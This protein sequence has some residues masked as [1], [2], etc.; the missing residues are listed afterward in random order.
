MSEEIKNTTAEEPVVEVVATDPATPDAP[1]VDA[2]PAPAIPAPAP[3]AASP[4]EQKL[5]EYGAD[6]VTIQKILDL[7]V[8][9]V[10]DLKQLTDSD[11]VGAGMKLV[12]ARKLISDFQ[13]EAKAAAATPTAASGFVFPSAINS[14][15][16]SVPTDEVWMNSLKTGGVLRID[17]STYIA[18]IKT[19]LAAKVGLYNAPQLLIDEMERYAKDIGEPVDADVFYK[20][21]KM[22]T[23][24]D[25]SDI[26][27][28][29]DGCSGAFINDKRRKEFLQEI[30]NHFLPAIAASY[31]AL[32]SWYEGYKDSFSDQMMLMAFIAG[33]AN[34]GI[35]SMIQT[36]D[37]SVVR[38]AR[39]TF[40][41]EINKTF[42]GCGVQSASAL[43]LIARDILGQLNDNRLP[44]LVGAE[45][46]ELMLKKL[47]LDVSSSYARL[48]QI[49]SQYVLAFVKLDEATPDTEARYLAALWQL[50]SQIDWE[51]LNIRRS[52]GSKSITGRDIL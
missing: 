50:G 27:A 5:T 49:L 2:T 16:P 23:R 17:D 13:A 26:F 33:G 19:A 15:L 41:D 48:E 40:V 45:N 11:L 30:D 6:S 1:V 18:A 31:R 47:S 10:D 46:R 8:E 12:K 39:D 24:H 35:G 4:V 22:L 9:T 21:V 51:S 37:T 14:I 20:L 44:K 38:A 3:T 29:I 42:A 36:P 52:K 7:G 28:A 32:D 43:A 34:S 25:Y